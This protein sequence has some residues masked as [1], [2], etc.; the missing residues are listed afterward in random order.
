MSNEPRYWCG[1]VE[2]VDNFGSP[3]KD[4]FIDGK[5][6]GGP[7]AIMSPNSWRARGCGRLGNGSGQKYKKQ[8]DGRWMKIEG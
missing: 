2:G 1:R 4:V 5:T 7:W 6:R 3:I 8:P